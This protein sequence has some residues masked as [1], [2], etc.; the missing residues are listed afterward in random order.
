MV[1]LPDDV[2]A[3]LDAPNIAHVAVNTDAGPHV[4]AVWIDR[5]GDRVLVNTAEGRVKPQAVREDPR[6]G[7]SIVAPDD[8]Y[9]NTVLQGQVVELRHEGAREHIDAM[10]R[11]YWGRDEYP[12]P[13]GQQR[14]ILVIEVDKVAGNRR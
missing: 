12:L 6:I 4:S 1:T 11:K 9:D 7:V 10:A 3:L 8:P 14:V 2:R 5:D 13:E